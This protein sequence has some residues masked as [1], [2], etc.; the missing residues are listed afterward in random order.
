MDFIKK[1]T[2]ARIAYL[3]AASDKDI[4][5]AERDF[6]ISQYTKSETEKIYEE[7]NPR[8][9][10]I[11]DDE[12]YNDI[13]FEWCDK[14]LDESN[15]GSAGSE[16]SSEEVSEPDEISVRTFISD[17]V[18]LA[19]CDGNL[20]VGEGKLI[21]HIARKAGMTSQVF[22]DIV[23]I[24]Q[25]ASC[26]DTAREQV[27]EA[28]YE[29]SLMRPYADSFDERTRNL[30][31]Q[32]ESYLNYYTVDDRFMCCEK[33]TVTVKN[34]ITAGNTKQE[35]AVSV[36]KTYGIAAV[37][38]VFGGAAALMRN[39]N[40]KKAQATAE[41]KKANEEALLG[42]E[43]RMSTVEKQCKDALNAI[44]DEK[45]FILTNSFRHFIDYLSKIKNVSVAESE[46]IN[47]V[48]NFKNDIS[49]ICETSL[50]AS[51][52]EVR[53][54]KLLTGA[55]VAANVITPAAF[56]VEA[57][58]FLKL[59]KEYEKARAESA[60]VKVAVEKMNIQAVKLIALRQH[61]YLNYM[62]LLKLDSFFTPMI[63]EFRRIRETQGLDYSA[64]DENARKIVASAC[65]LAKTLKVL[66]DTPVLTET[67]EASVVSNDNIY[68]T[69]RE[70]AESLEK[71]N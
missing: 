6:L 5:D 8:I 58:K 15:D 1:N 31:S 50:P 51:K 26:L 64:Y 3:V 67:G 9:E 16:D 55:K 38:P 60:D 70:L 65:S 61:I 69:D 4:S 63:F 2:A 44:A 30:K 23:Y 42:A 7:Y 20:D 49:A 48:I 68:R 59:N 33:T 57:G 34:E 35:K 40:N 21:R 53:S 56:A 39:S 66:I 11:I 54:N 24:R 22:N 45:T 14:L 12:D 43:N 18:L 32:L 28:D 37:D 10:E 47:E 19:Q 13:V 52:T 36:L 27:F 25:V 29:Y 41:L 71:R 17:L 62:Q 46:V